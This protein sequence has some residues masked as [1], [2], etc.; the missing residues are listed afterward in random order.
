MVGLKVSKKAVVRNKIKRWLEEIIRLSLDQIKTGSDIVVM[1]SPE[2]AE[3]N[4][5]ETEEVLIK[6][7]KKAKIINLSN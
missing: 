2:I 5:Q 4:Y 3:K 7:F 6:L 1:V